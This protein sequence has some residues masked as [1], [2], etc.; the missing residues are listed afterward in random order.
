MFIT[1]N[2]KPQNQIDFDERLLNFKIVGTGN[3]G[4]HGLLGYFD[5]RISFTRIL[6]YSDTDPRARP[7]TDGEYILTKERERER[8]VV[9]TTNDLF[10]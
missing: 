10:S 3:R 5:V 2:Y 6:G 8:D 7:V 9:N 1:T 4:L